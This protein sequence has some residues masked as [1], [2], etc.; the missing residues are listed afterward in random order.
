MASYSNILGGF[1][2]CNILM[3]QELSTD[4]QYEIAASTFSDCKHGTVQYQRATSS[5]GNCPQTIVMYT[6]RNELS[7]ES[8]CVSK[9]FLGDVLFRKLENSSPAQPW[10]QAALNVYY[11][12]KK[13]DELQPHRVTN[14]ALPFLISHRVLYSRLRDNLVEYGT[15]RPQHLF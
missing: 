14:R 15:F 9:L 6:Q 11:S 7:R 10:D 1:A 13:Q 12:F 2:T 4:P 5:E 3:S 8:P